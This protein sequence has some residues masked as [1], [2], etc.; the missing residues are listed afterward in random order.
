MD[1]LKTTIDE[2]NRIRTHTDA[3]LIAFTGGKDSL[4]VRDIAV[5]I[6]KKVIPFFMEFIP[7]LRCDKE[8]LADSE[9]RWKNVPILKYPH[10]G[11]I[12]C[13]REG[14]HCPKYAGETWPDVKVFDIYDLARS[15]TQIP[16]VLTGQKFKDYMGRRRIIEAGE[17]RGI[18]APIKTWAKSDVIAYLKNKNIPIPSVDANS[19]SGVDLSPGSCRW[20]KKYYPDDWEKLLTWFPYAEANIFREEIYPSR[21]KEKALNRK[22]RT[23]KI[24]PV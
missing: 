13:L 7:D 14:T 23:A 15:D 1:V 19:T 3:V 18:F 10:W 4:V 9:R 21:Q 5:R 11:F 12:Q 22:V 16:A 6:F 24:Q 8:R 17:D 2:M 20:L